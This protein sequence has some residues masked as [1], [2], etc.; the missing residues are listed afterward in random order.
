MNGLSERGNVLSLWLHG[1]VTI[2]LTTLRITA[3]SILSPSVTLTI[4]STLYNDILKWRHCVWPRYTECQSYW[5]YADCRYAECCYAE[6]RGAGFMKPYV[7][8]VIGI[9]F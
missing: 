9:Q 3:L 7:S 8:K 2:T 5:C 4:S 6:S 1:A